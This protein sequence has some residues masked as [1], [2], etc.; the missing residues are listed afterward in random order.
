MLV[1]CLIQMLKILCLFILCLT[2]VVPKVWV[3][4]CQMGRAEAMQNRVVYFPRYHCLPV[5]VAEILEKRVFLALKTKSVIS[6]QNSSIQ[7]LVFSCAVW[8]SGR[9]VFTKLR[10]VSR[11]SVWEPLPLRYIVQC[12]NAKCLQY[13]LIIL[14]NSNNSTNGVLNI[15]RNSET[16]TNLYLIALA[17][18]PYST[19]LTLWRVIIALNAISASDFIS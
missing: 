6:F 17:I 3:A 2:R 13:E 11:S 14:S 5:S 16:L 7:S 10:F 8:G 12:E 9:E 1:L 18:F 15:R 4:K 19:N